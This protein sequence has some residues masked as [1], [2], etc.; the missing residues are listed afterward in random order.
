M[1]HIMGKIAVGH[2][3]TADADDTCLRVGT[4]VHVGAVA[5][6]L[7]QLISFVTD[8]AEHA[9][10]VLTAAEHAQVVEHAA[11]IDVCGKIGKCYQIYLHKDTGESR[12][13]IW[14]WR[15]LLAGRT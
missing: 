11:L 2:I 10:N 12:G 5:A 3:E 8:T 13:P 6:R 14:G 15:Q 9:V 1:N 4:F 7:I